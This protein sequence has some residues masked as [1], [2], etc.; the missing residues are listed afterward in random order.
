[1]LANAPVSHMALRRVE[2][3]STFPMLMNFDY[4]NY[5]VAKKREQSEGFLNDIS[6]EG[7]GC[8]QLTGTKK[9]GEQS[10][11]HELGT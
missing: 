2:V 4:L 6:R 9:K 10:E 3:D 8:I 5:V 11:R 7:L 1:M